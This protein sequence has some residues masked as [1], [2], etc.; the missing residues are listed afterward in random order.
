MLRYSSIDHGT[1]PWGT[2]I[3]LAVSITALVVGVLI[4][5]GLRP[6]S[7]S[8]I[9]IWMG[10]WPAVNHWLAWM[11]PAHAWLPA[12]IHPFAMAL[13]TMAFH[14][15]WDRRWRL[16][17]CGFWAVINMAFECGQC[18]TTPIVLFTHLPW[19]NNYFTS[20]KFDPWD[21]VAM[22]AGA[23]CAAAV[24]EFTQQERTDS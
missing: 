3:R 22:G 8:I 21:L 1:A 13:I 2:R 10:Q 9:S 24:G 18:A 11:K 7:G 23:A 19:L 6:S 5:V 20:G 17:T 15:Q 12:F 4:Y 14:P 16:G